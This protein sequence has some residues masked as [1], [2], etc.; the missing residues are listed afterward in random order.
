MIERDDKAGE[1]RRFGS[2][3]PVY[4]VIDA[5]R[6]H[7]LARIRLVE[8]GEEVDYPLTQLVADPVLA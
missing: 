8:T 2:A 3:G 5:R 7:P 6:E 4:E 1:I